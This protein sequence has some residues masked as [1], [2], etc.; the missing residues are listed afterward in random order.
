MSLALPL[1]T[2]ALTSVKNNDSS[3]F[4]VTVQYFRKQLF[5]KQAVRPALKTLT[6]SG[7]S[8]SSLQCIIRRSTLFNATL[9][10]G[11]TISFC[12]ADGSYVGSSSSSPNSGKVVYGMKVVDFIGSSSPYYGS[13]TLSPTTGAAQDTVLSNNDWHLY[14]IAFAAIPL[15]FIYLCMRDKCRRKSKVADCDSHTNEQPGNNRVSPALREDNF[16]QVMPFE[17]P[18]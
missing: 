14:F 9:T 8:L 4:D 11:P 18:S 17:E 13:T 6:A 1:R 2:S 7:Y 15:G 10:C 5:N 16:A 3:K 12:S